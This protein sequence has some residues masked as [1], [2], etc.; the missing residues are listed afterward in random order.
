MRGSF[1]RITIL[2]VVIVISG[3][4]VPIPAI[5]AHGGE[6]HG[7]QKPKST[8]DAKGIVTHTSR[9]GDV[10]IMVKHPV[11]EPDQP[12]EGR[13][14]ITS[15]DT[16]APFNNAKSEVEIESDNGTV[17]NVTVEASDQ[18]GAYSL[19]VPAMP[20][21]SYR[22]RVNIS[23]GG[24]TDTATFSGIDVKPAAPVAGESSWLTN[25]LIAVLFALVV[26]LLGGLL[27]IVWRYAG[28]TNTREEPVSI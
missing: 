7:D 17:F 6:D 12:A 18:P 3:L 16:N 23:H 11:L 9:L 14:F 4:F 25:T 24:E 19:K 13:L 15:F 26:V 20:L 22:M 8:A 1:S 10:E 21:G 27:V 2:L 28:G 5:L